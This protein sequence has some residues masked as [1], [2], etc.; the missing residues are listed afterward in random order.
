MGYKNKLTPFNPATPSMIVNKTKMEMTSIQ[1]RAIYLT[2]PIVFSAPI[3][4]CIQF[5]N[6]TKRVKNYVL[7]K[8]PVN[9]R[10]ISNF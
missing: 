4:E 2:V 1:K 8:I 10:H 5:H 3:A 6:P 9:K 7:T